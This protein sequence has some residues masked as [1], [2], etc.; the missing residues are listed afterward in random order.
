M[1]EALLALGG[2]VGDVRATFDRTVAMLGDGGGLRHEVRHEVRLLARSSD[3]RTPPWGV[4]D[5]PAFVNCCLRIDTSLTPRALLARAQ[6]VETALGR[7][8]GQE[9]RWGPRT[10]DIDLIAYDDVRCAAPD[11]TL[12]HPRVLERAFV[13]VPLAEIAPDWVIDG[14]TVA[15]ALARLDRGGIEKLPAR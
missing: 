12:P 11:L 3:Y 4:T 1:A 7:N 5:Q 13:L 8:R 14:I 9:R 6:A 15:A 10:I 2:N